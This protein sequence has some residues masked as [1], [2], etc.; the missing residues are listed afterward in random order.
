MPT[1]FVNQSSSLVPADTLPV[2]EHETMRNVKVV[3]IEHNQR[4]GV[5]PR[6]AIHQP[7]RHGADHAAQHEYDP[8]P[9]EDAHVA[10]LVALVGLGV[11]R[12]GPE[13]LDAEE[14]VLDGGQVGVGLDEHDVLDV[15]AVRGLG[16]EAEHQEAVDDGWDGEGEVVVL[17]PFGAEPQEEDAR[18]GGDEDA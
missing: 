15:H 2:A 16:P 17:E 18:D 10:V 12:G 4:N 5:V 9:A 13:Q 8:Q 6:E 11:A 14:A 3:K 7:V 1:P